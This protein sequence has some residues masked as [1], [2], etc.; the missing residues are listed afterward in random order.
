MA[1]I[2]PAGL[3]LAELPKPASPV[4]ALRAAEATFCWERQEGILQE[5]VLR[6]ARA[7]PER[8]P[9]R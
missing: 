4:A 6:A 8:G 5:L 9:A 7:R 2:M 3:K 1:F